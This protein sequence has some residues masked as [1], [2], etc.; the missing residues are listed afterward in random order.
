[1]IQVDTIITDTELRSRWDAEAPEAQLDA[2]HILMT[3]PLQ[4]SQPQRDSVRN[5]LQSIRERAL[6]GEDFAALARAHSQDPGNASIGGDLGTFGRGDLAKPL[7]DAAFALEPGEI[8][9]VVETPFGLHLVRLEGKEAPGFDQFRDQ[10]RVQLLQEKYVQAE[11]LYVAG[12]ESRANPQV[13]EGALEVLK[14]LARDPSS[15]LSGRA[16]RRDLV[17]FSGGSYTVGDFRQFVQA[18]PPQLRDQ[19]QNAPDEQVEAFLKGLA[20]RE[21]LVA[22]AARAG[23]SPSQTRVDSLVSEARAQLRVIAGEIGLRELDR[24]PD[25]AIEPAVTRAVNAALRDILAGASDVVPLGEIAFQLRSR[26]TPMVYEEGAG[27]ALIQVGQVRAGRGLAPSEEIPGATP[28]S[29]STATLP[30][31]PG[32]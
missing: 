12:V 19:V 18:S 31:P 4:A 28:P 20:Q 17:T 22:E 5:Q 30:A 16:A 11:S 6:A 14:E 2:S 29:D 10:F 7:E 1:V 8:S 21:L 3:Y 27:Q 25:E 24:A 32:E 15:Q 9:E 26:A 13:A 23:L